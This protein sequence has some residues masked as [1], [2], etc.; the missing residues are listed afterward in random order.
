MH[1]LAEARRLQRAGY[2]QAAVMV[3]RIAVESVLRSAVENHPEWRKDVKAKSCGVSCYGYF[4]FKSG[5]LP[6][7]A[8]SSLRSFGKQANRIAHGKNPSRP[9]AWQIIRQ[10]VKIVRAVKGGLA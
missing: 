2:Y 9:H 3:S 6:K 10:A 1:P 4:L 7:R 5:V 8:H